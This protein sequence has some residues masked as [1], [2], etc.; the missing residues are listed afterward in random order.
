MQYGKA[1]ADFD[2]AVA[3]GNAEMEYVVGRDWVA[4]RNCLA[5]KARKLYDDNFDGAPTA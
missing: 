3:V 4:L 2:N 5:D 1:D